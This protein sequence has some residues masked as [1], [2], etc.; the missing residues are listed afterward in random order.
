MEIKLF[1]LFAAN[2]VY[3]LEGSISESMV[4]K[5]TIIYFIATGQVSIATWQLGKKREIHDVPK[6]NRATVKAKD[7]TRN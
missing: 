1:I 7:E 3:S 4:Y 2:T 5:Q 6:R